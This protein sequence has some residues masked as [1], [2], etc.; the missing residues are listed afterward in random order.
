MRNRNRF[1]RFEPLFNCSLCNRRTRNPDHSGTMLCAECYELAGMDNHVN[2]NGLTLDEKIISERDA[3]LNAA[4]SKGGD[5]ERIKSSCDFLW[6]PRT[7][8]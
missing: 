7:R 8:M 2:D 1:T 4:V 3:L 6:P 5:A